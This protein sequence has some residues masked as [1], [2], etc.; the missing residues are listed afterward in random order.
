MDTQTFNLDRVYTELPLAAMRAQG[1]AGAPL[2]FKEEYIAAVQ[3]EMDAA[4]ESMLL[5]A[6]QDPA[7]LDE[8][9]MLFISNEHA[10]DLEI[11]QHVV[12]SVPNY[13][14]KYN[15]ICNSILEKLTGTTH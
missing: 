11:M 3:A 8:L 9:E 6:L 4:V 2:S 5:E 1:L 10:S 13:E 7:V 12:R 14:E 15:D